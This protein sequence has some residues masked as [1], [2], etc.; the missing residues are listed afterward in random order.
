MRSSRLGIRVD[1]GL[2]PSFDVCTRVHGFGEAIQLSI[3]RIV[4]P[5]TI[6]NSAEFC[7]DWA[8]R[9]VHGI[10]RRTI[11][12]AEVNP[13]VVGSHTTLHSF[14]GISYLQIIDLSVKTATV[15]A[16]GL[17]RGKYLARPTA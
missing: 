7:V 10:V 15:A 8:K 1:K 2:H 16:T 5:R 3:A 4:L 13:F 12:I 14:R 11:F 6:S 17:Q 9:F